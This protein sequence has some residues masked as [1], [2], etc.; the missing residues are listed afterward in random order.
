[1]KTVSPEINYNG[2]WDLKTLGCESSGVLNI[3]GSHRD[4]NAQ[5]KW[6]I[7]HPRRLWGGVGAGWGGEA[8]RMQNMECHFAHFCPLRS[9]IY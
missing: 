5:N 9:P 7:L 3:L 4:K 8:P 6:N 2:P 1:M